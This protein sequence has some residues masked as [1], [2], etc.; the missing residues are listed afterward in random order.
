MSVHPGTLAIFLGTLVLIAAGAFVYRQGYIR[1]R[2]ALV[3]IAIVIGF[4]IVWGVSPGVAP[5]S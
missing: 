1:S 2:A 5:S 4:F 3:A